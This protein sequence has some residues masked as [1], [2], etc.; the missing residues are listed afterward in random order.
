MAMKHTKATDAEHTI[1][2]ESKIVS[3]SWISGRAPAGGTARLE[4][5]TQFVGQ[6]SPVKI[7]A[8]KGSGGTIAS[9]EGVVRDNVLELDV[10]IPADIA[11]DDQVYYEVD[12]AKCGLKGTSDRIPAAPAIR[13]TN[14]RWSAPEARRG[15]ILTLSAE[16]HGLRGGDEVAIV[17]YE[18]DQDGA[19]DRITEIP[20]RIESGKVEIK[21]EYEYHEDTDEIPT[22]EEMERYG[23]SYNPPEYFFTI[24]CEEQEYGEQQESGLLRFKDWIEIEVLNVLEEHEYVLHLPDGTQR[25]GKIPQDGMIREKDVPPGTCELETRPVRSTS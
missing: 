16:A 6:R 23:G 22:Q 8:K 18:H 10:P 25:K 17:I 12:L 21:W 19:H 2:L 13:F 20:A 7:T 1:K 4:L 24:R 11:L 14:L 5:I 15:D 3:A 9:L